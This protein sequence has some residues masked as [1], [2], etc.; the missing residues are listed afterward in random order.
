MALLRSSGKAELGNGER[1]RAGD[2][3][4]EETEVVKRAE[5]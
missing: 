5:R 1:G 3:V 2:D 4:D